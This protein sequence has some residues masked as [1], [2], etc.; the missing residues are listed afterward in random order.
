[1]SDPQRAR[2]FPMRT[3]QVEPDARSGAGPARGWGG[4]AGEPGP[5][6]RLAL[7]SPVR[8]LVAVRGHERPERGRLD[9]PRL[10][11]QPLVM[12]D[13]KVL[14]EQI[15]TLNAIQ[16]PELI[17]DVLE[18]RLESKESLSLDEREALVLFDLENLKKKRQSFLA[19]LYDKL[20]FSLAGFAFGFFAAV[21]LSKAAERQAI[22][23]S[24]Q[25][26]KPQEEPDTGN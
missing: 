13:L 22:A 3:H 11:G 14:K 5:S 25:R 23:A 18:G 6:W 2:G 24:A 16:I 21:S 10:L 12:A 4:E 9:T 15:R 7:L 17:Y 1:M 26:P 8:T 20:L 19:R